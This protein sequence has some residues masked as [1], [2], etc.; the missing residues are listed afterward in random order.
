MVVWIKFVIPSCCMVIIQVLVFIVCRMLANFPPKLLQQA[1]ILLQRGDKALSTSS[2]DATTTQNSQIGLL[3]RQLHDIVPRVRV[4]AAQ[5]GK[6]KKPRVS[7]DAAL[8]IKKLREMDKEVE[9]LQRKFNMSHDENFLDNLIKRM[10]TLDKEI[11]EQKKANRNMNSENY[12]RDRA[13]T[14]GSRIGE[15]SILYAHTHHYF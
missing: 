5:A 3:I 15:R 10:Q 11:N 2:R 9:K 8:P 4:K 1:E 7:W 12:R 14:K 6:K 13:L